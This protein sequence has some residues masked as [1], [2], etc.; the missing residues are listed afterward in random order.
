MCGMA[1]GGNVSATKKQRIETFVT[2]V[3][4][5]DSIPGLGLAVVDGKHRS[6]V[7]GYGARDLATN[8]PVTAETL[9]GLGSVTKSFTALA[10]MQLAD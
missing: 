5:E 8:A 9:F 4:N 7:E 1:E 3:M 2:G 10:I 6:L